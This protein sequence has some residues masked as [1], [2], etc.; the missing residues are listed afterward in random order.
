MAW[1]ETWFPTEL[2]P[3]R[4]AAYSRVCSKGVVIVAVCIVKAF[5]FYMFR[6]WSQFL[7]N[8]VFKTGED[9]GVVM[10]NCFRLVK[11]RSENKNPLRLKG[12]GAS[13]RRAFPGA[14]LRRI[15]VPH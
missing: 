7:F 8:P 9:H 13:C 1:S 6:L 11:N 2:N 12:V 4:M 15:R 14:Y 3:L 10:E 5:L